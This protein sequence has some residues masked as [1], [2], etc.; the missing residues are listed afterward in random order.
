MLQH[1]QQHSQQQ[2]FAILAYYCVIV[3]S[4]LIREKAKVFHTS[5][6]K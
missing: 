1:L 4:V 3:T 5:S 2:G 6:K